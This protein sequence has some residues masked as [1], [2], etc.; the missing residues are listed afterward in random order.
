ME[1]LRG[2]YG[3]PQSGILENKLLKE[4]LAEHGYYKLPHTP[5]LFTHKTRPIWFTLV[6]DD[7]GIKYVGKQHAEHLLSVLKEF[8]DVEEDWNGEIYC[9][10]TLD[11]HYNKGYVDIPMPNYVHK[12]LI[13]YKWAKPKRPQFCHFESN[14]I[15][16]GKQSDQVVEEPESPPLDK[17]VEKI[18]QQVIGS[19]LY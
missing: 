10:I 18:V 3:L 15:R 2:M 19:F 1:I 11:W 4:R 7:F 8:Y 12:Q 14:P 16:Y 5:D 13:K 9:G 6:V 17:K